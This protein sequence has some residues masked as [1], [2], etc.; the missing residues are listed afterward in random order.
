MSSTVSI[1][2]QEVSRTLRL[3]FSAEPLTIRL[4]V[5]GHRKLQN[6]ERLRQSVRKVLAE[7]GQ[8]MGKMT[9]LYQVISPLAEGADRLVAECVL[10]WK[11][12]HTAGTVLPPQLTAVLPMPKQEYFQTF[13]AEQRQESI[14]EFQRLFDLADTTKHLPKAESNSEAYERAGRYVASNCDVLIAIWDGKPARGK[15]GT[16]EVVQFARTKKCTVYQI[17]S[18]TGKIR[19]IPDR[20]DFISQIDY[21]NEYNAETANEES[22]RGKAKARLEELREAATAAGLAPAILDPLNETIFPHYVKAGELARRYQRVHFWSITL[23]YILSACAVG[24]AAVLAL[25]FEHADPRLF[26]IEAAEIALVI[27]LI[28]PPTFRRWQ[29]KWIDYRYLAERLRA[30]SFLYIAGLTDE[31]SVPPPDFQLSSVSDSWVVIALRATWRMLPPIDD[32]KAAGEPMVIEFVFAAWIDEQRKWYESAGRKNR[33]ASER[34]EFFLT[35]FAGLTLTAALL[36]VVLPTIWHSTTEEKFSPWLSLLA[37]T[38]PALASA[39]A[40]ISIFRHFNQNAERY[41]NMGRHLREIGERMLERHRAEMVERHG[42][43]HLS[44]FQQLL[45]QADRAMAHEHQGWRVVFGIHL[46]GPG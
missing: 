30:S 4:G 37:V 19:R 18:E 33:E 10:E 26:L 31:T 44:H 3:P 43:P 15:G 24:T 6:A 25:I 12:E 21:L 7:I 23:A 36:H 22:I 46:P 1:A 17:H 13:S 14:Q 27:A 16:A 11:G 42:K 2:Q 20:Q 40:G 8:R 9:Y 29:R 39:L 35:L 38:L 34:L 5:T 41:E 45:Q 28:W 32:N